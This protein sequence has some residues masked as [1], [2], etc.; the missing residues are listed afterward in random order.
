[1]ADVHHRQ[2]VAAA[3]D[4]S[5]LSARLALGVAVAITVVAAALPIGVA[6]ARALGLRLPVLAIAPFV[7]PIIEAGLTGLAWHAWRRNAGARVARAMAWLTVAF[8]MLC[9]GSL[10]R[11]QHHG[12]ASAWWID[13]W[14]VAFY[15]V[16]ALGLFSIPMAR[17]APNE[18]WKFAIDA[19]AVLL[20]SGIAIWYL[21]VLPTMVHGRPAIYGHPYEL[22]YPLGD[23]LIFAT[24]TAVLLR[25]V[26]DGR[27]SAFPFLWVGLTLFALT[28]LVDDLLVIPPPLIAGVAWRTP[29]FMVAMAV[30]AWGL[31]GYSRP[32][33]PAPAYATAADLRVQPFSPL[34]YIA[35]ALV[36][37]VL[38]RRAAETGDSTWMLLVAGEVALTVLVV[39]R[40]V[41][42][43]RENAILVADRAARDNEARL[44]ALV[45]HSS[46]VIAV[47]D[48]A[49][50]GT[51]RYISPS[52]TRVLGY[53]SGALNGTHLTTLL[54][55]D[56]VP[57]VLALLDNIGTQP[58]VPAP[59][60]WRMRH[61]DGW[62][63]FVEAIWTNLMDEPTVRGVVVNTRD[64][65]ERKSLEARLKHQ[66][67]HDPLTG[68][69]NR[70][71]FLDRVAH[72]LE[73]SSRYS[74]HPVAVLFLDIDNY[75]AYN[76]RFGHVPA[77]RLLAAVARRL[78]LAVR[79]SDTVARL[80]GDEFAI[81]VEDAS[82][83]TSP[84]AAAERIGV[85]LREPFTIEQREVTVTASVGVAFA[86]LELSPADLLRNADVAMYQ[87]KAAGKGRWE[88]FEPRMH[89]ETVR[90]L[91]LESELRRAVE[92]HEFTLRYQPIVSL[93]DGVVRGMEALVRWEHPR[94][95]TLLPAEF[96]PLAES[97]G[98]IVPLGAW[99]LA[100]ACRQARVWQ[101][102]FGRELAAAFMISVNVSVHQLQRGSLPESVRL[103]IHDSG[104]DP[105]SLVLEMTESVL[106][107]ETDTMLARLQSLKTMGVRLAIDDFGT[108]YSSLS[109][110]KRFPIDILKIAK[111]FV[112]DVGSRAT[113]AALAG[114]IIQLGETLKLRTIAEGI[115][116]AA[117]LRELQAMGCE[118][119]QGY[120][121]AGPLSS[122]LMESL[123]ESPQALLASINAQHSA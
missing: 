96:I 88:L 32:A 82:E 105:A 100:E 30:I 75:K 89:D 68:L 24:L 2:Y 113:D 66:A 92:Q 102:R 107:H 106:M 112:D 33:A 13:L 84:V 51:I 93:R 36:A 120:Y 111:P 123:L 17:R 53:A 8:F 116:Q 35:L 37:A 39:V 56:D 20:G 87:A 103:A 90:R 86:S 23:V 119:G 46:D 78:L 4:P 76:D 48:P 70:A 7:F 47:I 1:M 29:C 21:V 45:Q 115:E 50:G 83:A 62:W 19:S 69:A 57:R 28:D 121:F 91:E 99:V 122:S 49:S 109:Y 40:Q 25:R 26:P 44:S 64:I 72:A 27:G 65:S 59:I 5:T 73:M 31:Y 52:V 58:G 95:G 94:R 110:L 41:T 74:R 79:A 61:Q 71:L 6:I 16:L 98:L 10:L 22:A 11:L 118:L 15:P 108:G 9:A 114:T 14:Y 101:E 63:M 34:P 43:V 81:L 117:Q 77:D 3:G 80:G 67:S 55:P 38:I 54:H 60:E 18:R 85:V 97:T 12:P 42:A 104:L